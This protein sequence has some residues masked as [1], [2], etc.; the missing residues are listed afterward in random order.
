MISEFFINI[1]FSLVS[2]MLSGLPEITWSVDTSSF[3]FFLD[4]IRVAGYLLPVKTVSSIFSLVVGLTVFRILV[5]I[6]KTIWN[7]LPLV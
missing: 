4:V 2:G 1:I 7:L 5:S 3:Q 6:P